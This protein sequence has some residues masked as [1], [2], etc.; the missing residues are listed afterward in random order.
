MCAD[1]SLSQLRAF[2]T[3]RCMKEGDIRGYLEA[4]YIHKWPRANGRI[5]RGEI[6]QMEE[7]LKGLLRAT[8]DLRDQGQEPFP[9]WFVNFLPFQRKVEDA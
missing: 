8:E 2:M 5:P 6:F 9:E 3:E 4:A 1:V 7:R